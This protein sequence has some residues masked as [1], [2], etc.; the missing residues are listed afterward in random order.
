[1]GIALTHDDEGIH[2]PG[3]QVNWNESRY[4]DFWDPGSRIGGWFRIGARPNAKYAEMSACVFLP[5]GSVA[6]AYDRA[7]IDENGLAAGDTRG[8]QEWEIIEPWRT[9]RVGFAGEMSLFDD[10]WVLTVPK[11]AFRNSPTAVTEID[12]VCTTEG[13]GAAMGQDQDQHHLIFLPGQADFHYQHMTRVTGTIRIG[14][15]RYEVAGR[16]GKD[17][18][19][20]PRNWHAKIFLRWLT[21]CIDD[22]N[23]FMLTRSKGPSAERRSGF[24]WADRE[25]RVVDGFDMVN[26]YAGAPWY[27]LERTEVTVRAGDVEWTVTGTPQNYLPLRHRQTSPDGVEAVLRIV[28][29]PAEWTFSDGRTATGHLEY[30]DLMHDGIPVGLHE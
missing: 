16:G 1:M 9:T 28:K 12:L 29:Q 5:D 20:G 25:F 4:I 26:H 15:D 19:W 21:C 3:D 17:H 22:D 30:H 13:L 14:A 23:G 27:Q 10:P 2:V 6:F 7:G 18:S 24:V 11:R 8:R